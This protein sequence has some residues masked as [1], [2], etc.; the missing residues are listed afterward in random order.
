MSSYVALCF[1]SIEDFALCNKL[2]Q[3]RSEDTAACSDGSIA[4]LVKVDRIIIPH[5]TLAVLTSR[6][7]KIF[8]R[9]TSGIKKPMI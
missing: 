1:D 2:M 8:V 4:V 6:G 9:V 5:G 7:R 3:A